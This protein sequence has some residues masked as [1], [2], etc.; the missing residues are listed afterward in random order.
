[1]RSRIRRPALSH[2]E[3]PPVSR[4]RDRRAALLRLGRLPRPARGGGL[5]RPRSP[6]GMSP[7]CSR[8]SPRRDLPAGHRLHR[9]RLFRLSGP[10]RG[11]VRARAADQ[12][13]DGR[14]VPAAACTAGPDRGADAR[15]GPRPAGHE[16][17]AAVRRSARRRPARRPC[18]GRT[19]W[20]ASG[21]AWTIGPGQ[22]RNRSVDQ[23]LQLVRLEAAEH[24]FDGRF[25]GGPAASPADLLAS[26]GRRFGSA[27]PAPCGG[28]Q[29]VGHLGQEVV[30]VLDPR[31]DVA[32][33]RSGAC[34]GSGGRGRLIRPWPR[35][36][37]PSAPRASRPGVGGCPGP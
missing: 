36:P 14:R 30:S 33:A 15:P 8:T 20:R 32:R 35:T 29:A 27:P 4:M 22:R 9:S 7:C 13:P 18:P 16:E 37:G 21:C 1:M 25:L 19:G 11:R 17:A 23:V 28:L 6:A 2:D 12:L 26:R 24:R 31:A 3:G 10:G 5:R 34:P